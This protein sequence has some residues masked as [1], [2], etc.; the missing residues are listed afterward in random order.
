MI[1]L[2]SGMDSLPGAYSECLAMSICEG[3]DFILN[4]VDC[5]SI[6]E[7]TDGTVSAIYIASAAYTGS[8]RMYRNAIMEQVAAGNIPQP[9][10]TTILLVIYSAV[11]AGVD[12]LH[13]NG[14][15]H[16]DLKMDNILVDVPGR[17]LTE[18]CKRWIIPKIAIADFGES[19]VTEPGDT[20]LKN[21]GTECIKAPEMLSIAQHGSH[22]RSSAPCIVTTTEACDI[23]SLGC[24]FY[25]I[26][27]GEYL[28][29]TDGDWFEFYYRVTGE[30][31]KYPDI[32]D[33]R[34]ASILQRIDFIDFS[35]EIL[36]RDPARRPRINGVIRK[37]QNLYSSYLTDET[38]FPKTIRMEL[39]SS[40]PGPI[41][42]REWAPRVNN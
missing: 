10:A 39:P 6:V 21:R 40:I 19:R 16:Y 31:G 38:I 36:V 15:I 24:L 3:K 30:G 37:F 35:R 41:R 33:E 9:I 7:D 14:I 29:S 5:G 1:P 8:L 4:L 13:G 23:W 12:T 27:T 42:I 17:D 34:T 11:L 18:A 32:L 20:C 28:F 26:I 25:E 2:H 22:N